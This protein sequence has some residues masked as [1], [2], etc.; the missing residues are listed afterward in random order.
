MLF[1]LIVAG[2]AFAGGAYVQ[3]KVNIAST[4]VGAYN[5]V[6]A[7]VKSVVAKVISLFHK[8]SGS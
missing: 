5:T 2:L 6:V 8:Q 4:V 1:T 3:S 7:F